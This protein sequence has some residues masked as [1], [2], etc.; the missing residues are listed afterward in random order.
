MNVSNK[1][2]ICG[3][4]IR[5]INASCCQRDIDKLKSLQ[6]PTLDEMNLMCGKYSDENQFYL[7]SNL[8]QLF[9]MI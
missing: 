9:F 1:I 7:F 6:I 5:S 2:R 3:F 4:G 8:S